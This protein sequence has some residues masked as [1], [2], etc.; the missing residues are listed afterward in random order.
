M[1]AFGQKPLKKTIRSSE[2][3][4]WR[5]ELS[6]NKISKQIKIPP[7]SLN[8]A[9]FNN[10]DRPIFLSST[11]L[12]SRLRINYL[13]RYAITNIA[14]GDSLFEY[15]IPSIISFI[16]MLTRTVRIHGALINGYRTSFL[17]IGQS[18][19]G[20]TTLARALSKEDRRIKIIEDDI[21]FVFIVGNS[22]WGF[23]PTENLYKSISHLFFIEKEMGQLSRIYSIS[24]KE[25]FKRIVFHSDVILR[26][27]D[28]RVRDRL[29]TLEKLILGCS[30]FVLV[31]GKDL[32][33]NSK[34]LKRLLDRAFLKNE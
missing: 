6:L 18:G 2:D 23:S 7:Y 19:A 30:S 28:C 27:G 8:S 24:H 11:S 33:D 17:L 13:K 3:F 31:N 21:T 12:G 26:K 20:K 10:K 15:L 1:A 29:K 5:I 32:K 4:V 34:K 16:L 22:A 9:H 14:K 25:A